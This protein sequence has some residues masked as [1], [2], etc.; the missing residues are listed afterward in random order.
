MADEM[1]HTPKFAATSALVVVQQQ[2]NI[3]LTARVH[4]EWSTLKTQPNKSLQ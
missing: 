4:F 1:R 3:V 2:A